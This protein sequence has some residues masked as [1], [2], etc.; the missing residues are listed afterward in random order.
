MFRRCF[1]VMVK[2]A[3]DCLLL[4]APVF[5]QHLPAAGPDE[6]DFIQ[7]GD[8]IGG[9][10]SGLAFLALGLHPNAQCG[11]LGP[12]MRHKTMAESFV[13]SGQIG[14]FVVPWVER[15]RVAVNGS[16]LTINNFPL[17]SIYLTVSSIHSSSYPTATVG[18][19][20][21]MPIRF[22][23]RK[24]IHNS[25]GIIDT[26]GPHA[27][28]GELQRGPKPGVRRQR[29]IACEVRPRGTPRQNSRPF[30]GTAQP[31]AIAH[32]I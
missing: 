1:G 23:I 28:A 17:V 13:E 21:S 2:A 8:A 3:H 9:E 16:V 14:E 25:F 24:Q 6:M 5:T 18:Q 15:A 22:L 4:L 7:P 26:T 10:G 29:R 30:F 11:L 20:I 19:S 32:Q 12:G 31:R 27:A